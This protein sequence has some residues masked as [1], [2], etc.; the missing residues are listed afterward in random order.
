MMHISVLM[1]SHLFFQ[2]SQF[3]AFVELQI[4]LTLFLELVSEASFPAK[5]C[6]LHQESVKEVKTQ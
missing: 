1:I 6:L 4:K 5:C 2:L 3:L